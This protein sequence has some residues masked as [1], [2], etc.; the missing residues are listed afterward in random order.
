MN[1]CTVWTPVPK[2]DCNWGDSRNLGGGKTVLT[3]KAWDFGASS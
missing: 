3:W 1:R 2:K